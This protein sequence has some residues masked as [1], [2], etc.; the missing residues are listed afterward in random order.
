M[1][2]Y[3]VGGIVL[4]LVVVGTIGILFA[5]ISE[6]QGTV[7]AYYDKTEDLK[8]ELR[9]ERNRRKDAEAKLTE[10]NNAEVMKRFK[11]KMLPI[12]K[13][14]IEKADREEEFPKPM[15]AEERAEFKRLDDQKTRGEA[16]LFEAT[17]RY[18]KK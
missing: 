8:I 18:K 7:M 4:A 6:L 9:K 3:I 12:I 1:Q 15:T 2:K 17:Q 11:E 16:K 5:R 10:I 13:D 14:I